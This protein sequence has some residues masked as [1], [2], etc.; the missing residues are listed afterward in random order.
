MH[1]TI[2]QEDDNSLHDD[3][4]DIFLQE[5][6]QSLL[7]RYGCR[8]RRHNH[9]AVWLPLIV[10]L[11]NIVSAIL[12]LKIRSKNHERQKSLSGQC[13]FPLQTTPPNSSSRLGV[14][15]D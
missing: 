11:L 14:R 1:G 3:V 10:E 7:G 4:T 13:L 8:E 2:I 15:Y 5:P 12:L 9:H 6:A